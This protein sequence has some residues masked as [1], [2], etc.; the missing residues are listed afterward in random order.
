MSKFS[1]VIFSLFIYR[2]FFFFCYI[3][4]SSHFCFLVIFVLLMFA[5]SAL[6]MFVL[7]SLPPRFSM[8]SFSYCIDASTL[9]WMLAS[10]LRFLTLTASLLHFWGIMP[11]ASY[12]FLVLWSICQ[13][14]LVNLRM[15]P[16]ILRVCLSHCWDFCNV[17]W[18]RVVF[19]FSRGIFFFFHLSLFDDVRFHYS[20]VII[21]CLYCFLGHLRSLYLLILTFEKQ[22]LFKTFLRLIQYL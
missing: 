17:V 6:F 16:S 10:R 22:S 21:I 1:H 13:T 19:S 3:C 5:L 14:P 2:I 18:F 4:F 8:S 7:I 15:H 9:S 20:Q 12:E 11:Y